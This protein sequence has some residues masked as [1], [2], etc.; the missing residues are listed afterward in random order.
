MRPP[1]SSRHSRRHCDEDDALL[2]F[3][4]SGRRRAVL[5]LGILHLIRRLCQFARGDDVIFVSMTAQIM[6]FARQAADH[7]A[8]LEEH[9]DGRWQIHADGLIN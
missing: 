9:A 8:F 6:R 2:R 5:C 7:D 1:A 4:L 3:A